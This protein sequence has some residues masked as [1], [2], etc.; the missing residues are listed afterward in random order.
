LIEQLKINNTLI[1]EQLKTRIAKQKKETKKY[2]KLYYKKI[3]PA[4]KKIHKIVVNIAKKL[5]KKNKLNNKDRQIVGVLIPIKQK[6]DRLKSITKRKW[7]TKKEIR[8]YIISNFR[9]I[10]YHFR[11]IKDIIKKH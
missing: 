11:Q 5:M 7:N 8:N 6:L 3:K 2:S 9:Q 1:K 4:I 10:T